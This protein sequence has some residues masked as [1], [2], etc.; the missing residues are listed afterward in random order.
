M[1]GSV[2]RAEQAIPL[3][4]ILWAEI[5]NDTI[6]VDYVLIPPKGPVRL[7]KLSH[8]LA[9][10][11][12][13]PNEPDA[14]KFVATVLE[15]AYGEVRHHR[16]AYVLIN[17]NS[18]PGGAVKKW[19]M[20]AKPLL[21]AAHFDLDVVTLTRGGEATDLVEKMDI[22]RYDTVM[23]CSGDGTPHEIIN[24]LAKR[25]DAGVA[26]SKVAVSHIPCG[27]GNAMALNLYGSNRVG[28][29]ALAII[30]GV[31][32]P[33]DLVSVTQ[34]PRRT[35]SF[36]SQSLGMVAETDLGTEHMRWMG[37]T[38]FEVG[39]LQRI[40]QKTSY[41]CDLAVKVEVEGKDAIKSYYKRKMKDISDT[42]SELTRTTEVGDIGLPELKYGTVEDKLPEDWELVSHDNISN[43][44]CGNMQFM[45]P[46][47]NFFPA[48][49][50]ADGCMD[51]I[52]IPSDISWYTGIQTFLSIESGGF[53]DS[54]HVNYRKISG[55]RVTPRDQEDGYISIDGERVPFEPFQAEIHQ[56]LGRVIAKRPG[57]YEAPGPRG[58]E[59]VDDK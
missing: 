34:G 25:P 28:V 58:W 49:L 30:K 21:Q 31:T 18:G 7:Q 55:F 15:R 11:D 45:S 42:S 54:P 38:R 13:N 40:F 44:Y 35:L 17:P 57:G 41:P 26:L 29:V 39:V 47:A 59:N 2:E 37:S 46:G 9:P 51:L 33:M 43:V 50:P 19:E 27:S 8:A 4:N 36:L 16:R 5:S 52:T 32:S 10:P 22:D 48:A 3:Y 56:G 24:G 6:T 14:E 23:A 12:T 53:F 1:P 20:E